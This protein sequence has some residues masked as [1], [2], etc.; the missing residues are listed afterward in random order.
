M[1][2]M[3]GGFAAVNLKS[4]TNLGAPKCPKLSYSGYSKFF[5]DIQVACTASVAICF[6]LGE[7]RKYFRILCPDHK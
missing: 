3:S 2:D 4:I 1:V 7:L 6:V 5:Y